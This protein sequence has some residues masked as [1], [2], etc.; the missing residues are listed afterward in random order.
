MHKLPKL[1]LVEECELVRSM[2]RC[3]RT[4]LSDRQART[5]LPRKPERFCTVVL[6]IRSDVPSSI[7]IS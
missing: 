1:W 5:C 6:L 7:A 3:W 2:R 4:S